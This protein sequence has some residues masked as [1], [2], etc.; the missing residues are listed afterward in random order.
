MQLT[1][2]IPTEA[3]ADV[4]AA[5]PGP[6]DAQGQEHVETHL[7]GFV[8]AAV[9][10]RRQQTAVTDVAELFDVEVTLRRDPAERR[11]GR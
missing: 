1:I 2:D 5:F 10:R 11:G 3:E 9:A 7:R 8:A 6:D 4:L